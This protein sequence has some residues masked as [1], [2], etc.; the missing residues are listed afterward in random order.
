MGEIKVIRYRCD[1]CG[2]VFKMAD[3]AVEC[4]ANHAADE[5]ITTIGREVMVDVGGPGMPSMMGGQPSGH[6]AEYVRGRV[7]QTSRGDDGPE[8]LVELASG[9]REWCSGWSL[10]RWAK[11]KAA[12]E[13]R[14]AHREEIEAAERNMSACTVIMTYGK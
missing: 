1:T 3:K 7:V 9:S 10:R 13:Y 12:A 4:E 8:A 6:E 11:K 5:E 14:V 2:K